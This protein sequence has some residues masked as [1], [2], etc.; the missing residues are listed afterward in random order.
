MNTSWT[1]GLIRVLSDDSQ[2]KVLVEGLGRGKDCQHLEAPEVALT[3]VFGQSVNALS[4]SYFLT[5]KK[6]L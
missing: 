6:L 2:Q 3:F 4:D 5:H 1:D